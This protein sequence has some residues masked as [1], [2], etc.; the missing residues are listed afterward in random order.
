MKRAEQERLSFPTGKTSPPQT[1]SGLISREHLV[2]SLAEALCEKALLLVV[3]PAGYGKTVVL[4]KLYQNLTGAGQEAVWYNC[5]RTDVVP[6]KLSAF[7]RSHC[8]LSDDLAGDDSLGLEASASLVANALVMELE[9]HGKY[10]TLFLENYHLG[11]SVET[12]AL[13]EALLQSGSPYLKLVVSSRARPTF[14]SRKLAAAGQV[15]EIRAADLAFTPADLTALADI[16]LPHGKGADLVGILERTEGWPLAIRLFLLALRKGADRKRLLDEMTLREADVLGFL[17]EEV[18]DGQSGQMREFLISSSFLDQFNPELCSALRSDLDCEALLLE[19]EQKGLFVARVEPGSDWWR[20]HPIFK[21]CLLTHFER[22]PKDQQA[23]MQRTASE[24]L[25]DQGL[26]AEAI[27]MAINAGDNV[28]AAALLARLAPELVSVRGDLA[29]YLQLLGRLPRKLVASDTALQFWQAWAMFFARRYREA[30]KLVADLHRLDEAVGDPSVAGDFQRQIGLLD[31]LVATFTDDMNTSRRVGSEWL[32]VY[33]QAVPFDR[34]TVACAQA[35]ANLAFLDLQAARRAYV[36]AQRAIAESTST[37]GIAWVCGIG[38][39]MDLVAGEPLQ[40]LARLDGMRS[41]LSPSAE[42]PSNVSSTLD[43]LAAAAS[44]H[45]GRLDDASDALL[46]GSELLAE[47][48]VSETASFGL[49]ACIRVEAKTKGVPSALALAQRLEALLAQSYAPRLWLTIR[50]ERVLLLFRAG[51][52]DEAIEEAASILDIQPLGERRHDEVE[53]DLPCARELRQIV[54]ARTA[55]AEGTWS[56]ALRLLSTLSSNAR[57]GGRHL[58]YVQAQLLKAAVHYG[59]GDATKAV[60]TFREAVGVASQRGLLQIF[61]DD[62][63]I[64]RPLVAAALNGID[65]G[66]AA[67]NEELQFLIKLGERFGI[68][69]TSS[70]SDEAILTPLEPL[71]AR[72]T[73][74]IELL[75]SGMRNREIAERLSTSE[76]TVKW[77]LYNLYSKLGVNNRTAA[78]HRARALGLGSG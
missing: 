4:S 67:L 1:G 9:Q 20:Y 66:N 32:A 78:I 23:A 28:R 76:A 74:M 49:A 26:V 24:W 35:L 72:E 70:T 37:Y 41:R 61:L 14:A 17:T 19:A 15:E 56:E 42:A 16:A 43:F 46:G 50:Y 52:Q 64:C 33:P 34:A 22:L 75:L 44:Y 62:E 36:I 71:T 55:I 51:R 68:D 29:T 57:H 30:A 2:N 63:L 7:L 39:T 6:Q 54:S 21:Q 8:T 69:V 31:T 53:T 60:R 47:H 38:M 11:Q 3:A 5:D 77:H 12:N 13:V 48:G 45:L 65:A 10:F 73:A 27:D 59:Q 18:L 58:R 40:A 25:E